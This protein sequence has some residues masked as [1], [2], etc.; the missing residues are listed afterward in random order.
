MIKEL[1]VS[2]PLVAPRLYTEAAYS[3][4]TTT[5][6]LKA[7]VSACG[8]SCEITIK[9]GS[10]ILKQHLWTRQDII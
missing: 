1:K 9:S 4:T 5:P 3:S 10:K 6:V 7:Y 8:A 2:S